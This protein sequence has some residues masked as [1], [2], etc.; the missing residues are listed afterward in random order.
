MI[1][2]EKDHSSVWLEG[3]TGERIDKWESFF[4]CFTSRFV[5]VRL[6]VNTVFCL[7]PVRKAVEEESRFV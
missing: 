7:E 3:V 1:S 5:V 6:S 2:K 4:S